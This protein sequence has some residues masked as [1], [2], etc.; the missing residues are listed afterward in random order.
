MCDGY[1]F[2]K[3]K[4]HICTE[5]NLA[6]Y[7]TKTKKDVDTEPPQTTEYNK[8]LFIYRVLN[9]EAREYICVLSVHTHSVTLFQL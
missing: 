5:V 6:R 8:G 4:L 7:N 2:L 3:M 9:N 1:H